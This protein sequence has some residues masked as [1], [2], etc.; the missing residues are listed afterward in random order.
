M[1]LHGDSLKLLPTLN[2]ESFD[3]CLTDPP[4][5]AAWIG[6]LY[7]KLKQ[8]QSKACLNKSRE[9]NT[10][11]CFGVPGAWSDY[12]YKSNDEYE[13]FTN[14]WVKEVSSLLK[15]GSFFLMFG[16]SKLIPINS[17]IVEKHDFKLVDILIWKYQATFSRGYSLKKIS[18]NESDK[19]LRTTIAPNYEPILLFKKNSKDNTILTYEKYGTGFIDNSILSSNIL[20]VNKPS[21]SEKANNP[22]YSIKPEQLIEKL[23]KGFNPKNVLDPFMGSG[24]IGAIC[25]N[26]K[27]DYTGIEL[28]ED[29]FSFAKGRIDG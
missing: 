28:E 18:N 20:E 7:E 17:Q 11:S 9:K 22:H 5:S 10:W 26:L 19:N 2:K 29:F 6:S 13:Q 23:L 3:L 1:I 27:I 15:P 12:F 21:K 8:Y 14:T 25:K 24:T 16:C 4:Y